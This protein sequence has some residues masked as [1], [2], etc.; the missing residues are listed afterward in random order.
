MGRGNGEL[1]WECERCLFVNGGIGKSNG[2]AESQ[3]A[4]KFCV[5]DLS[6]F[7]MG[8]L[9][10]FASFESAQKAVQK[11]S[12]GHEIDGHPVQVVADEEENHADTA[13]DEQRSPSEE[14][15]RSRTNSGS[16]GSAD[17]DKKNGDVDEGEEES[18]DE[19][20]EHAAENGEDE[21]N[22][23][24]VDA[25]GNSRKRLSAAAEHHGEEDEEGDESNDAPEL[26]KKKKKDEVASGEVDS[27]GAVAAE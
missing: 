20:H 15:S 7:E 26:K 10:E 19:Q 2:L 1:R 12:S 21:H 6:G 22:G 18:G 14:H 9:V 25:N 8:S 4:I 17:D 3:N 23:A 24:H 5:D 11:M 13:H 16:S 27:S